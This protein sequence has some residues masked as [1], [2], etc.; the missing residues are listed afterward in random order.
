MHPLSTHLSLSL[1]RAHN[2]LHFCRC[3]PS[4]NTLSSTAFL[5]SYSSTSR[6]SRSTCPPSFATSN[7]SLS[8]ACSSLPSTPTPTP[9]S[10]NSSC[11]CTHKRQEV[12]NMSEYV[13]RQAIIVRLVHTGSLQCLLC[14]LWMRNEQ[15]AHPLGMYGSAA[16]AVVRTIMSAR[17]LQFDNHSNSTLRMR[18]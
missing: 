13:E 15:P 4:S 9:T 5:T 2:R 1:S 10:T 12:W 6:P 18:L 8:Y 17:V 16:P 3:D 7:I 14:L 11:S